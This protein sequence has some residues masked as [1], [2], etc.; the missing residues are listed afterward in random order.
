MLRLSGLQLFTLIT[1]GL[2]DREREREEQY[3]GKLHFW[4][5]VQEQQ[6]QQQRKEDTA[7]NM[8]NTKLRRRK[9]R[10]V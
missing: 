6:Q 9:G 5:A 8:S 3:T 1:A 2:L 4:D 7:A 10:K